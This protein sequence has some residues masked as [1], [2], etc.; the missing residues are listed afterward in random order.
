MRFYSFYFILCAS[1]L[2]TACTSSPGKPKEMINS[3][4]GETAPIKADMLEVKMQLLQVQNKALVELDSMQALLKKP[5]LMSDLSKDA[6]KDLQKNIAQRLSVL[7]K[8]ASIETLDRSYEDLLNEI[9]NTALDP[10]QKKAKLET[11]RNTSRILKDSIT[12]TLSRIE[13]KP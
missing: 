7:E 10:A 9:E 2:V 3:S 13:N 1:L 8:I 6:F 12:A 11:L 4:L 5:D